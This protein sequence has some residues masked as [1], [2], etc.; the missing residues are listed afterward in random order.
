MR[1]RT[2]LR[3]YRNPRVKALLRFHR[4]RDPEKLVL[5][6]VRKQIERVNFPALP[7]PFLPEVVAKERNI[8]RIEAI[9]NLLCDAMLIKEADGFVIRVNSH[10]SKGRR[11]FSCFHEIA[12]TFFSEAVERQGIRFTRKDISLIESNYSEEERLCD[13]AAAEFLIPAKVLL[14]SLQRSH[15]ISWIQIRELSRSFQSSLEATALRVAEL[16]DRM[17]LIDRWKKED[18]GPGCFFRRETIFQPSSI[19]RPRTEH[20]DTPPACVIDTFKTGK[21]SQGQW[22]YF[23]KGAHRSCHIE[24]ISVNSRQSARGSGVGNVRSALALVQENYSD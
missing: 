10:V 2:K 8:K 14:T 22:A 7:P 20:T 15:G 11:N 16:S 18:G 17:V 23:W 4:R 1:S 13:L 19:V 21:P 12:H 24:A 3:E 9:P 5:Q 6:L